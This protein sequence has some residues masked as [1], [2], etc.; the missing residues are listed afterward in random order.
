MHPMTPAGETSI[1]TFVAVQVPAKAQQCIAGV[2][3]RLRTR[4]PEKSVRWVRP[5]NIHLTLRFVGNV[6]PGDLDD[7]K[8]AVQESVQGMQPFALQL[9]GCGCFPNVHAPRVLWVGLEGDLDTLS[10]LQSRVTAKTAGWGELEERDFHPHLTLGRVTTKRRG[11][12]QRVATAFDDVSVP[13][14]PPWTVAALH[15]MQSQLT[16]D[17]ARYSVL[18]TGQIT[19]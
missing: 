3:D 1:R 6:S 11:E 8:V 12:L 16:P 5:E 7:L 2:I 4:V 14:C 9:A 18:A 15:L 10:A 17:G 19:G 13:A